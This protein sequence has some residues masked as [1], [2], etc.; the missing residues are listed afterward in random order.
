[1]IMNKEVQNQVDIGNKVQE[2]QKINFYRN[3]PLGENKISQARQSTSADVSSL[4]EEG[5]HV[6]KNQ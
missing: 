2:V 4:R 1:M 5:S 3:I 6:T